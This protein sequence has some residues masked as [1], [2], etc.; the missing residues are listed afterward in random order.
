MEQRRIRYMLAGDG[1]QAVALFAQH[2]FHIVLM[3]LQLPRMGG[4]EA[5]QQ[6]RAWE[7]AHA[8]GAWPSN[9]PTLQ[10]LRRRLHLDRSAGAASAAAG[11]GGGAGTAALG[12][13]D[14]GM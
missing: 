12:V 4:L 13:W 1:A 10:D 5:T 14:W 3:D 8:R 6:I 9:Q 11:S 2:T 7:R